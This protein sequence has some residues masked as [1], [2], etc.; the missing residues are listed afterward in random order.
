MPLSK[1]IISLIAL[2]TFLANWNDFFWAW[3]VTEKQSL[4]TL[5]VAL[6]NIS[7]NQFIKMN[8]IMG[9]SLLSIL[10]V[11]LLTIIFSSQIKKSIISSG[12]KG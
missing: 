10:P 6:Y 8:F 12:I 2:Q 7:K 5:N 3:L 9:L 11:M 4:W 1:P